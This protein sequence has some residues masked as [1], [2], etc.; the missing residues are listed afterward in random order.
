MKMQEVLSLIAAVTLVVAGVS[1]S[2]QK[3]IKASTTS[4]VMVNAISSN[5]FIKANGQ[6]L[7]NNYGNGS[8]VNLHGTNLGSWNLMEGWMSPEGESALDRS[9]WVA[10]AGPTEAGSSASYAIDND[11]NS[12]W[13]TGTAQANGQWFKVD[14][15]S[16]Q[17]FDRITIDAGSSTG[18]NPA[19][20]LVQG[21]TDGVH[22]DNYASGTSTSQK[23]DISL[24]GNGRTARYILVLQQGSK[25]NW[26]SIS[27]FNVYVSDMYDTIG[28]LHNRFG[29]NGADSLLST[30]ENAWI[31]PSDLDNIKDMGLNLVR[32]P[33]YW[34][35][36]LN[37]DGSWKSN[38]FTQ[39][40]NLVNQCSQRGIYV[41]LDLHGV[42]GCDDAWQSGGR[43]GHDDYFTNTTYQSWVTSIWQGLATHYNGNPDIAGYDLMNEPV[44][45]NSN[46]T[47]SQMY[48]SLYNTVRAIDKDHLIVMEA[49]YNFDYIASPSTYGWKN[50]MYETHPYDMGNWNDWHSQFNSMTSAINTLKTYKNN[51]NVP[52]YAGEFCWYSYNDIWEAWLSALDANGINWTNWAYKNRRSSTDYQNGGN[53]GLYNNF[54]GETPD[55]NNDDYTTI[56]SKW[57]TATTSNFTPNAALI[58]V[59][60]A[61]SVTPTQQSTI[62]AVANNDFVSADKNNSTTLVGNRTSASDWES[63]IIYHNSDGTVS[64]LSLANNKFVS[65][66][67][68]NSYKLIAEADGL[69]TYEKFVLVDMGNGNIALKSVENNKYVS[70]DLNNGA[71]LYANRDN[72]ST[73]ETF[74]ISNK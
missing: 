38:A 20:Y 19:A 36:F 27:D 71:V 73:W 50:V 3:T 17:Y 4:N 34:E 43:L 29:T 16:V 9:G 70:C 49:F 41:L 13:T 39:L 31:Q 7:R 68:N 42:P 25:G 46:Y 74:T 47:N 56:A 64:L 67:P 28:K 72:A 51:W 2:S 8:I 15:G 18:D 53:W 22:W 37:R 40:D 32:V 24:D 61:Q 44:S 48:N 33:L 54:T 11:T 1:V 35:T 21:S 23:I 58:N 45:N 14:M 5:D 12:R 6:D 63:F 30:Y 59:F 62:K 10:A 66:D 65:V 69:N 26:W 60:K 52:V 55:L 57:N